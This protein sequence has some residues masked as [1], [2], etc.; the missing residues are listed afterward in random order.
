MMSELTRK[1]W[2]AH[3]QRKKGS[4][5]AR[6]LERIPDG[7]QLFTLFE[8]P[9]A[10]DATTFLMQSLGVRVATQRVAW[11]RGWMV[12]VPAGTDTGALLARMYPSSAQARR[13]NIAA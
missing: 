6:L 8:R 5:H 3:E 4:R 11:L 12:L 7:W 10:M 1:Q 2:Q 13:E 9:E